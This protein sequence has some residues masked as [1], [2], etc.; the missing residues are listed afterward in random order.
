MDTQR[1]ATARNEPREG[2]SVCMGRDNLL[3]AE[4]EGVDGVSQALSSSRPTRSRVKS[5][6]P[7]DRLS[8][9]TDER[10][11]EARESRAVVGTPS[12]RFQYPCLLPYR[13]AW[14][15]AFGC[16]TPTDGYTKHAIEGV[17]SCRWPRWLFVAVVRKLDERSKA[18]R[19]SPLVDIEQQPKNP[20][21]AYQEGTLPPCLCG[22]RG[23]SAAPTRAGGGVGRHA[24][25]AHAAMR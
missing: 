3:L 2:F 6:F 22:P 18:R 21:Q 7:G 11:D 20:G 10:R 24:R 14:S 17:A 12:R 15:G 5:S 9:V 8:H 25:C 19:P 16:M 4:P 1:T 13:R 23:G